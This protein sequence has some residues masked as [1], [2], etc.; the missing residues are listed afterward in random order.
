M[1]NLSATRASV[2]TVG[3]TTTFQVAMHWAGGRQPLSFPSPWATLAPPSPLT[4]PAD[5]AV[6]G[7]VAQRVGTGVAQAQVAAGQDQR[8]PEVRQAHHALV[9]VV[10]VLLV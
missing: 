3:V 5:G 7:L 10:A 6:A 8:V 1:D 9:A 4:Q 2:V